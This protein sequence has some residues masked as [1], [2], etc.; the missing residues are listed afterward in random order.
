VSWHLLDVIAECHM[1]G[2]RRGEVSPDLCRSVLAVYARQ[3]TH[4][5]TGCQLDDASIARRIGRVTRSVRRAR[6]EL[7]ADG[8]LVRVAKAQPLGRGRGSTPV[9]YRI[10]LDRLRARWHGVDQ[11]V[12]RRLDKLLERPP[13]SVLTHLDRSQGTA[14]GRPPSSAHSRYLSVGTRVS[15]S[16][17]GPRRRGDPSCP[18]C[19][20][21][22]LIDGPG[23][24]VVCPCRIDGAPPTPRC[25]LTGCVDGRFHNGVAWVDCPGCAA[26]RGERQPRRR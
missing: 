16:R 26:L 6:A 8:L 22:G 21:A 11:G 25:G 4:D 15:D 9:L 12:W 14:N 24:V 17:R 20:G 1:P 7:E 2:G 13:S 5:G 23:G 10:D 19:E 18:H 3:A